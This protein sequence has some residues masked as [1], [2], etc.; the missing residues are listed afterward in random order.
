VI[1]IAAA[2][3]GDAER[4]KPLVQLPN[5]N[6]DG[7]EVLRPAG[8][9]VCPHDPAQL[10]GGDAGPPAHGVEDALLDPR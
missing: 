10:L 2:A 1:P 7:L 6:M 3:H 8:G 5:V 4:R 9:I